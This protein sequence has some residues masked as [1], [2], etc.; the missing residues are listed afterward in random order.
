MS[1]LITEL[2]KLKSNPFPFSN[3]ISLC[4]PI[5]ILIIVFQIT[6]SS[7]AGAEIQITNPGSIVVVIKDELG[8]PVPGVTVELKLPGPD[9]KLY[10]LSDYEITKTDGKND[11]DLKSIKSSDAKS[12]GDVEFKADEVKGNVKDGETFDIVINQP[13]FVELKKSSTYNKAQNNPIEIKLQY[14][15]KIS[16]KDSSGIPIPGF[17]ARVNDG[18]ELIDGSTMDADGAADG[19]LYN[20]F[21]LKRNESGKTFDISVSLPAND[22]QLTYKE[23]II[24]KKQSLNIS[25]QEELTFTFERSK[26]Q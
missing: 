26:T 5:F 18:N 9:G 1:D 3:L 10:K 21:D 24:N 19:V 20:P 16:T 13:G 8:N 15:L 11:S 4:I 6:C 25:K 14:I 23:T 22:P 12:D 17:S 2:M 7:P